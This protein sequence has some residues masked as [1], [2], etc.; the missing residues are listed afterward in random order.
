M[1]ALFSPSRQVAYRP[2]AAGQSACVLPW[3]G[4]TQEM[5]SCAAR[6]GTIMEEIRGG[7][8][9]DGGLP[10]NVYTNRGKLIIVGPTPG[11][12]PEDIVVSVGNDTVAIHGQLRGVL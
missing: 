4:D 12:E 5:D 9:P 2:R 11:L 6:E 1:A 10:V 7:M 8:A 3:V